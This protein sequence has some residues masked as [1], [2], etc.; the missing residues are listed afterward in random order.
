MRKRAQ[1]QQEIAGLLH[2][3]E[4]S[5]RQAEDTAQWKPLPIQ[6]AAA[7]EVLA[8]EPMVPELQ[9]KLAELQKDRS[10]LRKKKTSS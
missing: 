6:T 1:I 7:N 9:S 3:V 5:D 8:L 4:T 2:P 10:S